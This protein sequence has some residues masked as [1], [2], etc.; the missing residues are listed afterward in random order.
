MGKMQRDKGKEGER[1]V[2]RILRAHGYA[3]AHRT[4]Q[5]R[6]DTGEAADV[7][8]L[9]GFHLE[10]KRQEVLKIEE[11]WRQAVH[12]STFTGDIPV[13][14]FRKNRQDWRVCMDFETF[15]EVIK[16]YVPF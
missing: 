12:D 1:E 16:D 11:W 14:V 6:G 8:G 10:V 9:P 4:A 7:I 13:L 15:L 3:D 2:A 5:V